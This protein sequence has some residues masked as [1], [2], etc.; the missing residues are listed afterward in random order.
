ML[1]KL[2]SLAAQALNVLVHALAESPY[3]TPFAPLPWPLLDQRGRG[4]WGPPR[5]TQR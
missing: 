2:R 5:M 1:A 4:G 3:W